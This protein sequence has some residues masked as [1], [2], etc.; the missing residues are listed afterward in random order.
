LKVHHGAEAYGQATEAVLKKLKPTQN[1]GIK[2]A[3]GAFEGRD[4]E[5]Q[6]HKGNDTRS[7]KQVAP[8]KTLL[9]QAVQH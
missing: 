9:H 2:L 7:H 5:T 1:R 4:E 8:D 6:Q 3:L